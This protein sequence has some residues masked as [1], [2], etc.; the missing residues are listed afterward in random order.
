MRKCVSGCILGLQLRA[1]S[2]LSSKLMPRDVLE[3]Y[4]KKMRDAETESHEGKRKV[5]AVW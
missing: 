1:A 4:E 5:E 2:H 3:E